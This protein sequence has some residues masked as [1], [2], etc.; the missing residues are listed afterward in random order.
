MELERE[1]RI[2]TC[3]HLLTVRFVVPVLGESVYEIV[4]FSLEIGC[5]T[6]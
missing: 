6:T 2:D 3:N 5:K 1:Y 4:V